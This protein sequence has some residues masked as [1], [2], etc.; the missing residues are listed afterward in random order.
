M[1]NKTTWIITISV[2]L[3]LIIAGVIYWQSKKNGGLADEQKQLEDLNKAL[4]ETNAVPTLNIGA[5]PLDK[6]PDTNPV[7]EANPFTNLKTNP[8]K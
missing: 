8:F 1:S 7:T 5:N 3:I 4:E 2:I 6:L